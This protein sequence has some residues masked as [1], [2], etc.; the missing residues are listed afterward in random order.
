MR[1]PQMIQQVLKGLFL[2]VL[3]LASCSAPSEDG[4]GGGCGGS[5]ASITCLNVTS[6]VPTYLD[7]DT[8]NVDALRDVCAVDPVTGAVTELEPFK[9]HNALVTLENKQFPTTQPADRAFDIGI[10]GYSVTYTLNQPCPAAPSQ[11]PPLTGFTTGETIVIPA[12]S[13]VTV[14]LPFVPLSVKD[15]FV[16]AV[17]ANRVRA[18]VPSYTVTYTFTAHTIGANDTF[19]VQGNAQFTITDFDNCP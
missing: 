19:T 17:G 16:N 9:D 12:G 14:T 15:Q 11:C 7:E 18:A 10:S 4:A 6:I 8:T 3:L 5:D 1:C 13:D 2:V